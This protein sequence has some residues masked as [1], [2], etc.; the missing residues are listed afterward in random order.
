MVKNLFLIRHAEANPADKDTTDFNR[1]LSANG[2]N[3]AQFLGRYLKTLSVELEVIYTSPALRTLET[4]SQVASAMDK[5]PRIISSEEYY[6]AT[7]NVLVAAV[8]RLDDLFENVA[9]IGHNPF[10]SNTPNQ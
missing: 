4:C 8:N 5:L 10:I 1:R 9:I 3:E 2:F 7:R 6:E